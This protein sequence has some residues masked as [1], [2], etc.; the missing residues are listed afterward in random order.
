MVFIGKCMVLKFLTFELRRMVVVIRLTGITIRVIWVWEV[1]L[2]IRMC[3]INIR[4]CK[5]GCCLGIDLLLF[6]KRDIH[7]FIDATKLIT[8]TYTYDGLGA[9]IIIINPNN[10]KK[11]TFHSWHECNLASIFS[12]SK[13]YYGSKM[14]I[15]HL[16]C[17]MSKSAETFLSKTRK[18]L[19]SIHPMIP[20]LLRIVT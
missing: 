18:I 8:T 15:V 4:A 20:Y 10:S 11:S 13:C 12:V 16:S 3:Q 2:Y 5:Y 17:Q 9:K 14:N 19:K 6:Y 7:I 1:H